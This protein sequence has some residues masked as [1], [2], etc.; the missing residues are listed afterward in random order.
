MRRCRSS[1][2]DWRRRRGFSA[3]CIGIPPTPASTDVTGV[4]VDGAGNYYYSDQGGNTVYKVSNAGSTPVGFTGL[5]A[6]QQLAV[7]GSGAIYVLTGGSQIIERAANGVQFL[8]LSTV[9]AL[10]PNLEAYLENIGAFALDPQGDIY[11]GGPA[12]GSAAG[13]V[14]KFAN[15]S[16]TVVGS[17]YGTIQSVTVG[18]DGTVYI[19]SNN[20]LNGSATVSTIGPGGQQG[21]L[22]IAL[23]TIGAIAVD[24]GGTVYLAEVAQPPY[25]QTNLLVIDATGV[26]TNYQLPGVDIP[27]QMA[28][29]STGGFYIANQ[30]GSQTGNPVGNIVFYSRDA[31]GGFDFAGVP[32]GTTSQA[33]P[34]SVLNIGN[35]PLTIFGLTYA[36]QLNQTPL[37]GSPFSEAPVANST[38]K[39]CGTTLAG[40]A[41]CVI[42][43]VFSPAAPGTYT[44][45]FT[46][47]DNSLNATAANPATQT[48]DLFGTG[49]GPPISMSLTGPVPSPLFGS[50]QGTF[51]VQELDVTGAPATGDN[52]TVTLSLTGPQE[53]NNLQVTL[54]DGVGTLLLTLVE[55]GN[56]TLNA[57]D[58][59]NGLT[60]GPLNFVLQQNPGPENFAGI[61]LAA[62]TTTPYYFD[63]VAITATINGTNPPAPTGSV[64]YSVD[65]GPTQS[66]PLNVGPNGAVNPGTASFLVGPLAVGNHSVSV[67]Y[68]PTGNFYLQ[69]GPQIIN[70][71][72]TDPPLSLVSSERLQAFANAGTPNDVAVDGTGDIYLADTA[73]AQVLEYTPAGA[74]VALPLDLVTPNGLAVDSFGNVYVSDSSANQV[75]EYS[76]LIG[77][78]T[79]SFQG[80]TPATLNNPGKIAVDRNRNV[81]VADTGN[82]RVVFL[83]NDSIPNVV[84]A[85]GLNAPRGV[86]VD[87][88]GDIFIA[89]S[90][91][92]RVVKIDTNQN[93][94]T[95]LST[96]DPIAV[97]V[98]ANGNVYVLDGNGTGTV[99]RIDALGHQVQLNGVGAFNGYNLIPVDIAADTLGN[100][101]VPGTQPFTPGN[102]T[103]ADLLVISTNPGIKVQDV[104]VGGDTSGVANYLI[105][106]A[107]GVAP[108]YAAT[109][110]GGNNEFAGNQL[111]SCANGIAANGICTFTISF[112]PSLPGVR[113][114]SFT[115]SNANGVALRTD[116]VYGNGLAPLAVFE[117]STYGTLTAS[118][119]LTN[120]G[121]IAVDSAENAYVADTGNGSIF[122]I[123]AGGGNPIALLTDLGVPS[124]VAVDG[125]GNVYAI[126]SDGTLVYKIAP[127]GVTTYLATDLTQPSAIVV[128]GGGNVFVGESTSGIGEVLKIDPSGNE[129]VV[130]QGLG[131]VP[132]SLALDTAGNVYVLGDG[133]ILKVTP[134]LNVSPVTFNDDNITALAVDAAGEIYAVDAQAQQIVRQDTAGNLTSVGNIGLPAG[135]IALDGPGNIFFTSPSAVSEITRVAFGINFGAVAVGTASMP[136]FFTT[137]NVGNQPLVFSALTVPAPFVPQAALGNLTSCSGT[138]T[139]AA[140]TD[141]TLGI[142]FAPTGVGAVQENAVLTSNSLNQAAGT[143]VVN[144]VGNGSGVVP[145]SLALTGPTTGVAGQSGLY[146]ITELGAGGVA[147]T[148]D[149]DTV[150]IYVQTGM[151][152]TFTGPEVIL[153]NGV[154]TFTSSDYFVSETGIVAIDVVNGLTQTLPV[155]ITPAQQA[156][157]LALAVNPAA[158][159]TADPVSVVVTLGGDMGQP[160]ATG[161]ITYTLDGV[162]GTNPIPVG[163]PN[164]PGAYITAVPLGRLTAGPHTFVAT[165]AGDANYLGVG[166]ATLPFNVAPL[167]A[168]TTTLAITAGGNAVATVAAATVVTLT[169]AVAAG[170]APLSPGLVTFCDAAA[171][172]CDNSAI[173][174]TA[175]LTAAGTAVLRFVPGIGVHSYAAIFAGTDS[176]VTSTSV[177]E[178][179]TVTG[180][181]PTVTTL[182]AAG[183]V[184]DYTVT[185]TVTGSIASA[186]RTLPPLG[187][188]SF[189]DTTPTPPVT[190]ATAPVFGGAVTQ[191]FARPMPYPTGGES[192][193]VAVG[194]FNGDGV[195]DLAV[196]NFLSNT[197]SVLLGVGNGTFQTQVAYAVGARPR[198]VAIGDFNGDG[199]LDLAVANTGDNTV[200]ILIGKGDGTFD[201][202]VTYA[203]GDAPVSVAAGDFNHDGVLDLAVTDSDDNTVSILIGNGDGSFQ[204]E[205]AYATGNDPESVAVG[206]FNG[207]GALDLAVANYGGGEGNTVSVLLG[208]GDGS[209]QTQVTYVTGGTP[210]S[211]A[212]GDFNGDGVPDLAVA[213]GDENTVSVLIGNGDGT[214]QAQV[215]YAAGVEATSVA[216]GDF[217]GDGFADLAIANAANY[218]SVLPGNGDGTF[219]PAVEYAPGGNPLSV[220]VGD[221]N[222]DGVADLAVA[223]LT[224][225]GYVEIL[226]NQLTATSTATAIGVSI[227]GVGMQNVEASYPGSATYGASVSPV[228]AFMGSGIATTLTLTATPGV[229][230]FG[231]SVTLTATLNPFNAGD[232]STNGET[233]TFEHNLAAIGTGTLLNGVA[234]FTTTTLPVGLDPLEAA[235][236]GDTT[237]AATSSAAAGLLV[238]EPATSATTLAISVAG[239]AVGT[240]ASGTP[241]T[242]TASV[243]VNGA[244]VTPGVVTFCDATTQRCE[245]S[246]LVGSAQLT[247]AG[248]AVLRFVPGIGAHIY[249]AVFPG[250]GGYLTSASAVQPLTV[251]GLY[252]TA[253]TI[254]ATGTQGNYTL[255]G[256]VVGTSNAN[257]APTGLLSFLDASNSNAS[258]GTAALGTVTVGLNLTASSLVG[259][260]A[261]TRHVAIGDFNGDG[262]PDVALPTINAGNVPGTLIV[263]LGNGDGTFTA[264]AGPQVGVAPTQVVVGDF[265]GDGKA[266]LAV[267]NAGAQAN[268]TFPAGT[269]TILLGNGDGTFTPQANSPTTGFQAQSLV[270]GDFNGD[271]VADLAV[272]NGQSNTV[273]ILLGNGDG[274]FTAGQSPATGSGAYEIAI[275]DFN[276]DGVPDLAVSNFY[277]NTV[278]VLLGNGDG[279]FTAAASPA[280]GTAP[281]GVAIADFNGD[282]NADIAV[283]NSGDDTVTVLL[284]NGNGGFTAAA[285]PTT[286]G[287]PFAIAAADFNGDGKADLA[288]TNLDDSTVGILLGNGDGT[289]TPSA[290][291]ATGSSPFGLASGDLNGDGVPDLATANIGDGSATLVLTQRTQTATATLPNVS[292]PGAG[293]HNVEASFPANANFSGSVSPT[294]PLTGL[295]YTAVVNSTIAFGAN[296]PYGPNSVTATVA[297]SAAGLPVP[298]GSLGYTI[299]GAPTVAIPGTLVN[300]SIT[301]QLPKIAVG[302]H[303]IGFAYS[304]D[305]RFQGTP[306]N[307]VPPSLYVLFTITPAV[308][309]VTANSLTSAYGQALPALT[310]TFT[311]FLFNDTAATAVTG[312]PVLITTATTASTPANYPIT[313]AIGTLAATN[314][315]FNFVP[316]ALTISQAAQTIAFTPIATQSYGAAAFAATATATSGL[317]V[318]ISVQSGPATIAINQV[319][320]NGVGTVV[321]AGTQTGNADYAAA[322]T[323]TT[324]FSV[325]AASSSI[326]LSVTSNLIRTPNPIS[327]SATVSSAATGETGTVTFLDGMT[328][329]GQ[330]ALSPTDTAALNG[331]TLAVG[332]HNI[333]AS[334]SGTADFAASAS[335]VAT[336]VVEPLAVVL[337]TIA[338]V[339]A[340]A[341]SS[342]TTIT[343]T[344][345]NFSPT[346]IVNFNGTPL[347]TT[348]VNA[349]QLTAVIPAAQLANAGTINVTVSDS[350]SSSA[351]TPQ[352][353]TILPVTAVTFTG[354]PSTPPGRATHADFR[355]DAGVRGCAQ[356]HDDADVYAGPREPG[357]S[358]GAV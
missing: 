324:S 79:L 154:G 87:A 334:Y 243:T 311:G 36:A 261:N 229:S 314:Y 213:N 336:V 313:V 318:T 356:R 107:F 160:A 89:D 21:T 49:I 98:D 34:E 46:L 283:T 132:S 299:D 15:G 118:T 40:G 39:E 131:F 263:L 75:Y 341:G 200:S 212:V 178:P 172:H 92:N 183:S 294:T 88:A 292:V 303:T 10:T 97:T 64:T 45:G 142:A 230:F 22:A 266:D 286:G 306:N 244:A 221:F 269:V 16:L 18:P 329:L 123:P 69:S 248:K 280:T 159:T 166:P 117:S 290:I 173:L 62:S 60:A 54:T 241:V 14:V 353:F 199:F 232:V 80:L 207:D 337:T 274:T 196:A 184:E 300:G 328:T 74:R 350:Y 234:T 198:S 320:V 358:G 168:T 41:T 165:Y 304:G 186:N 58:T 55:G 245:D 28:I 50:V 57:A 167:V 236:A 270:T 228:T 108:S 101:F 81:Y 169:A 99:T 56:Y 181:F 331:V 347:A 352:T 258:L 162:A 201:A 44:G 252:P 307:I 333:T 219:N 285:S 127:G 272:V 139:L 298:T 205:V 325:I 239:N 224:T 220:A 308:L 208:N 202:Q 120:P 240:V 78:Q 138:L 326:A 332:T 179:L 35:E 182:S 106:S 351:S 157:T 59:T 137:T 321:L 158:P 317:P 77:Q 305:A 51:T 130:V 128:D 194:D 216:V 29:T 190:V 145:A 197:V 195:P 102:Q 140:G 265:N 125:L 100:L 277:D 93:Q 340:E 38:P 225:G 256:T 43:D 297:G 187:T 296:I 52:N 276:G 250:K 104:A 67:T 171:A 214:F 4:A 114:G 111:L 275:G 32:V 343:A 109:D 134:Y 146:T 3:F 176:F 344:G 253:T 293:T 47:S 96:P 11:V 259:G 322:V 257:L 152:L 357:R 129:T 85:T 310:D 215:A 346:A 210:D 348:F 217:N 338:P 271:G 235:Y 126:D 103:A 339:A 65:N 188:M 122:K 136:Y 287:Y 6:P 174:G 133:A 86:A 223:N 20:P 177:A 95:I 84:P 323:A 7:D 82:N 153:V 164:T 254:A 355:A 246:A 342:D 237:F 284:G 135:G 193:F 238:N 113:S 119:P 330:S 251:T 156:T 2:P 268:N 282:G 335:P 73:G 233:I 1:V 66:A 53:Y 83:N 23:P 302:N 91:S 242:L 94:T 110:L 112:N 5:N 9:A 327:L 295:Q 61:T 147:A 163:L 175:Q 204:A 247:A 262:I 90:G 264:A 281:G 312:T 345:T 278:S 42:T 72:A 144:L 288:V 63:Q 25:T 141:C 19:V 301:F 289:F 143:E 124:G 27:N 13:E 48:Y 151:T 291:A 8:L 267:S 218:V 150:A 116:G 255:T 226:L 70:L 121:P 31:S 189:V 161:N 26:E 71:T 155:T 17:G 192:Y 149:S 185:A 148:G 319:T 222:G 170:G 211:V 12:V 354:P 37:P 227:P 209:F 279:T 260:G 30:S 115:L 309:T 203:T 249:R 105:P 24:A 316:G 315:T 273:T 33:F 206:D 68:V 191:T 231:E 180:L 76:A 349:T